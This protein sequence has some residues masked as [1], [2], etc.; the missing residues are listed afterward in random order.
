MKLVAFFIFIKKSKYSLC[1]KNG[2]KQINPQLSLTLFLK[3]HHLPNTCGPNK[4]L[5]SGM[6][7]TTIL[8]T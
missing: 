1:L 2:L 4:P 3:K 5:C 6:L 7:R 8:H